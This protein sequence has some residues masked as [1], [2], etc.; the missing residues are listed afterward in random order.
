MIKVWYHKFQG[1]RCAKV[2]S[3]VSRDELIGWAEEQ[4]FSESVLH[5][6]RKNNHP[7]IDLTK[8][9][10]LADGLDVADRREMV[11]DAR[12]FVASRP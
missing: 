8:S 9:I 4:G 7:H 3:T 12:N 11:S 5:Y 10:K 2:Y 6:S 1:L